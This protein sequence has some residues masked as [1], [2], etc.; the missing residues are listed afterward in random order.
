MKNEIARLAMNVRERDAYIREIRAAYS[1]LLV[2]AREDYAVAQ[3]VRE[4]Y[5]TGYAF[6]APAREDR[7]EDF[8]PPP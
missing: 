8:R 4:F 3:K 6:L 7:R 1:T 5:G 2:Q